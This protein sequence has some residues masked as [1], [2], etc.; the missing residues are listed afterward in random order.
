MTAAKTYH[1]TLDK[2]H[3]QALSIITGSMKLTP[4]PKMED[5]T[6]LPPLTKRREQKALSQAKRY[7]C[8]NH[9][10]NTTLQQMSSDRLKRSTSFVLDTRG[11][12]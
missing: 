12:Q 2:V 6:E 9:L 1:Q 10:M 7:E 11:I 3:N 5:V 4:I 8:R